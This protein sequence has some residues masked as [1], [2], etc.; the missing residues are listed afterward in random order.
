[1]VPLHSTPFSSL[2]LSVPLGQKG[3]HTAL[4][5][6][7][8]TVWFLIVL[9]LLPYTAIVQVYLQDVF[10]TSMVLSVCILFQIENKAIYHQRCVYVRYQSAV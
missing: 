7:I 2:S 3:C 6:G 9:T 5:S 1:M 10:E 4:S 8:Q